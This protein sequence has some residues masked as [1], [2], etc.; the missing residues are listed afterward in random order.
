MIFCPAVVCERT[1]S[2]FKL[3]NVFIPKIKK[4][5]YSKRKNIKCWNYFQNFY[6]Y[7]PKIWHFDVSF[8]DVNQN[9][10]IWWLQ[11]LRWKQFFFFG[12]KTKFF[13]QKSVFIISLVFKYKLYLKTKCSEKIQ[14]LV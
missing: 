3:Q 14:I 11:I 10:N 4:Q 9:Q 7:D 13:Q 2:V 1:D 5:T 12:C 8:V 6:G